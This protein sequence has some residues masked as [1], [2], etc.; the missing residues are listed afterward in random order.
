VCAQSPKSKGQ[1]KP[2]ASWF[3]DDEEEEE[4]QAAA[5]AASKV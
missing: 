4:Q 5:A 2:T 3:N 1:Q